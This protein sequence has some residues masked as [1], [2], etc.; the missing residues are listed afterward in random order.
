[1]CDFDGVQR[2]NYYGGELRVGKLK[3]EVKGRGDM[4]DWICRLCN[5]AFENGV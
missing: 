1:M 2:G 3:D 4:V 5:I